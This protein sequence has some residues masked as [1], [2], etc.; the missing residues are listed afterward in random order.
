LGRVEAHFAT[1]W[2]HLADDQPDAL[3]LAQG[4]RE[5]SW[6]DYELRAARLAS[7]L[8]AAGLRPGDVVALYLRNAPEY[9]EATF[10]ACK[11][12]AIPVNVNYRYLEDELLGL[13]DDSRARVV[14][15]DA[16][17]TM[18][19][20]R[21]APRA[22][23]V[24]LWIQVGGPA[25][26]AGEG[27]AA[28]LPD[29]AVG[30]D[31]LLAAYEPAA[32][33]TRDGDDRWI[34]YTGGT[35]GRPRGVVYRMGTL[36]TR[37]LGALPRMLGLEPASEPEGAL[38]LAREL[39]A[40]GTPYVALPACPLMHG[41]GQWRGVL[42]PHMLG[43]AGVL[44]AGRSLDPVEVWEAVARHGVVALIVVGDT[45]ARPVLS[46]VPAEVPERL[47]FVLSS[48]TM[49]SAPVKRE[50]LARVPGLTIVDA[51]G[52]SEASAGT[53]TS[54]A[55]STIETGRFTPN[56]NVRVFDLDDREVLPGSGGRGQYAAY[57]D[58]PL[59]YHRDEKKTA[60]IFRTIDGVRYG[61]PGDWVHLREDGAAIFLGRDS[62]CINTGGEKVFPEEVE[63]SLKTHPSVADAVVI[64]V[65]DERFGSRVAAVV[66]L[67]GR[68]ETDR[69]E[70]DESDE[71][72][73]SAILAHVRAQLAGYKVPI[74]LR[75][76]RQVPRHDHG[77][78][79]HASARTL[80][81]RR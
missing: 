14:V 61:I 15:Y 12:R 3:A 19:V 41:L 53:E 69:A 26:S 74:G 13:L 27:P 49:L 48:G 31:A 75:F 47:R 40:A 30:Y 28:E 4:T 38:R 45:V 42:M 67:A 51:F 9:A 43:G 21:V 16:D 80:W 59:G 44:L 1:V 62:S 66:A 17:L 10:A 56:P 46:A 6:A 29:R 52:A 8:L 37:F 78:P 35:T 63:E 79:D 20:A 71:S 22:P 39:R 65:P 36:V 24:R 5:L 64:G 76:V 60:E 73:E 34:L 58:I 81:D 7:A 57:G 32:R 18:R 54:T 50:L 70:P 72:D 2:E 25:G 33:T 77:K 11:V 68:A 55:G 23:G